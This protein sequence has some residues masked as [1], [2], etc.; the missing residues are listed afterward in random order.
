MNERLKELRKYLNF[1]MEQFGEKIG[2]KKNTISQLESGK[3]NITESTIKLIC[4][5][6]NVNENWLR[7]GNGEMF[8]E[9]NRKNQI[10]EF[11][12][13]LIDEDNSFKERFV[14]LL[15]R[16]NE[17]DWETLEKIALELA[18]NSNTNATGSNIIKIPLA[19]SSLSAGTGNLL[20]DTSYEMIEVDGKKYPKAEVAF[21]I[22][23]DS[24]EPQYRDGDIVYIHKQD[25]IDPGEVG[26]F[27]FNGEQFLK[28]LILKNGTYYLRSFNENYKDIEI[29]NDS[30]IIY[31]KVIN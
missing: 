17:R 22:N 14:S 11:V 21:R 12:D 6:F 8:K 26:A 2:M 24:M 5:V 30:L 4:S 19:D 16:L 25:K 15:T 28:Q 27:L 1:T 3:N 18:Q 13:G 10:Q 29:N 9:T 20:L 7:T 23:G 31:G